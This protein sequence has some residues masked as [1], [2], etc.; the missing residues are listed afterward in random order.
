[1][2]TIDDI[3][4]YVPAHSG[5]N[6]LARVTVGLAKLDELERIEEEPSGEL[7]LPGRD[8]RL[9]ARQQRHRRQAPEELDRL[10]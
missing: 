1:V 9:P 3:E 6:Y 8:Q 2:N 10:R 7:L 4:H 5:E